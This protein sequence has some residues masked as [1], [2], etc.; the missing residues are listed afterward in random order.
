MIFLPLKA[1]KRKQSGDYLLKTKAAKL[2]ACSIE[3]K[4][5]ATQI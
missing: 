1:K 3:P 5:T 4:T 2:N